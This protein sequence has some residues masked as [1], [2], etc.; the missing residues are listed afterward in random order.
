MPSPS[1]FIGAHLRTPKTIFLHPVS[2]RLRW[3]DLLGLFRQLGQI[4]ELSNG[5][6]K[7]TRNGETI[8]VSPPRAKD[9]AGPDELVKLRD[10]LERSEKHGPA[11]TDANDRWLVVINHLG[12]AFP[13]PGCPARDRTGSGPTS[14]P[15]SSATPR[16]LTI[17]RGAR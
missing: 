12:S 15:Q 17:F 1:T 8:V 10:F 6:L 14:P 16:V 13:A 7:V 5:S 11:E 3:R 9:V 4:E 2:H